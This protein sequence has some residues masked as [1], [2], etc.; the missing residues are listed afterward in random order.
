MNETIQLAFEDHGVTLADTSSRRIHGRACSYME[1]ANPNTRDELMIAPGALKPNKTFGVWLD[2]GHDPKRLLASYPSGGMKLFDTS[3]HLDI[4]ATIRPGPDGDEAVSLIQHG[5]KG[6]SVEFEVKSWGQHE[7]VRLVKEATLN[8]VA[9]V[10]SPAIRSAHLL[11]EDAGTYML[12]DLRVELKKSGN[13]IAGLFPYDALS[14]ISDRD[15]VR[16]ER[17]LQ[18]AFRWSVENPEQAIHLLYGRGGAGWNNPLAI[19]SAKSDPFLG[20]LR[21]I[22]DSKGVQFEAAVT[23]EFFKIDWMRN[24]YFALQKGLV[25][26]VSPGYRV[27]P[28]SAVPD[29]VSLVEEVGNPGVFIRQVKEANL[30]SLNLVTRP[31]FAGTEAIATGAGPAAG[32]IRQSARPKRVIMVM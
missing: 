11:Q 28:A 25:R 5:L 7:G 21:L 4:E 24:A 3:T 30:Y 29:A 26:G 16:K 32:T 18:R 23:D 13:K 22:E 12:E 8:A 1:R 19:R 20:A 9:L 31:S 14:V 15:P 27:P 17:I 2:L 10:R 6:L